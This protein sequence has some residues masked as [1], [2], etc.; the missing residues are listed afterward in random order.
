MLCYDDVIVDV[1]VI[2]FKLNDVYSMSMEII[3]ILKYG[4]KN[5]KMNE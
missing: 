1:V 5:I 4:V 2:I 3:N